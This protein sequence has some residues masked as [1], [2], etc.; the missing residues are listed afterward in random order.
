LENIMSSATSSRLFRHA[1]PVAA[2][3]AGMMAALTHNQRGDAVLSN[4]RPCDCS[5]NTPWRGCCLRLPISFTS[6]YTLLESTKAYKH[7]P[8]DFDYYV[9]HPTADDLPV[10]LEKFDHQ[11]QEV[12][13]WIWTH[14]NDNGPHHVFVGKALTAELLEKL[15]RIRAESPQNNILLLLSTP[16]ENAT[17]V[18]GMQQGTVATILERCHCGV[19]TGA[20]L[21]L[22]NAEHKI[23]MLDDER[24]VAFDY[25]TIF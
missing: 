2:T 9:R 4:D 22:L 18:P 7:D 11:Q 13:P 8:A 3:G 5:A 15:E 19:V 12:W 1:I 16:E 17:T 21:E 20:K 10:L 23:L 25:L 6:N 24:V 14:P